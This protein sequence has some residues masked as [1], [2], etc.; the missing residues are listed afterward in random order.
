MLQGT[1]SNVGKSILAT[2]LCRIFTQEGYQVAPFK[3]WNMA[4][5]SYVTKKGG[6]IGIAQVIQAQA[7]Q[8]EATV[9]MQPFLL[10]PKGKGESQVIKHGSP[11]ADLDLESQD[12]GYRKFALI[13]IEASLERLEQKFEIIVMEGAGSPAEINIKEQDLANMNV[14]KMRNTPVLLVA[15]VDKGGALAS[16]VGTIELLPPE[17]KELVAG[18]ILNKFRGDKE[19]LEP[20]LEIIE[21][22]TG[23][24]VL[25]VIPYLKGFRIP[26]EDSV[27]LTEIEKS[28]AQIEIAVIRLPHI[29]NFTDLA[30]FDQEPKTEVRYIQPG[31]QL[32]EPDL[33]IIPGTKNTL[34]DLICLKESGLADQ[35]LAAANKEIPIIGICGGYQMLGQK[36][37][38]PAGAESDWEEL[39]GLGLLPVET[40][41]NPH[42]LTFQ[43]EAMIEGTG[44]FFADLEETKVEGYEIHMGTSRL[45]AD[46]SGAFRIIQRGE[47]EV[48]ITDGAV[49]ED[50]LI[51]GTYLHGLFSNDQFRRNLIN[52]LRE[53]KGLKSLDKVGVSTEEKL[54]ANYE[55]LA[56]VVRKNL[57]LDRIYEIME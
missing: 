25:G 24:P 19:L 8:T 16:V 56:A 50:G 52:V 40:N 46:D 49:S 11:L 30:P 38:D 42:K 43:A 9:D 55:K 21:E 1:A 48:N 18:V 4:L 23:I 41:F 33:I 53:R 10:K 6:E 47:E 45:L 5:N 26:A 14:A 36:I 54:E 13:E 20:G 3:G 22:E 37:Y 35:L 17:E 34:D 51:F 31:D 29:S 39:D 28:E 27:A 15:D 2:A 44:A 7:A 57:D 32:K 12:E